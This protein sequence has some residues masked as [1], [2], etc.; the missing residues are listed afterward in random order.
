M[1][2]DLGE[3]LV[4]IAPFVI[5]VV[6]VWPQRPITRRQWKSLSKPKR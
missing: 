2:L 6:S 5:F 1:S 4:V 3:W